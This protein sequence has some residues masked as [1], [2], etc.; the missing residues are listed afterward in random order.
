MPGLEQGG[1]QR[2]A[3]VA[4][5]ADRGRVEDP[6]GGLKHVRQL[7]ASVATATSWSGNSKAKASPRV[8][9]ARAGVEI[10]QRQPPQ[11][12][13]QQGIGDGGTGTTGAQLHHRAEL[14]VWQALFQPRAEAGEVGVVAD[15]LSVPDHDGVDGPQRRAS[16]ETSSRCSST[17]CLHGWV[18]LNAL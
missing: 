10:E 17:S 4:V 9:A 7:V 14:G 2:Q 1:V 15:E 8:R 13:L 5:H 3:R 12:L 6:V 11:A 18:M 16:S